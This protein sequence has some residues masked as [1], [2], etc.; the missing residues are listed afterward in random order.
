MGTSSSASSSARRFSAVR[1]LGLTAALA[2]VGL[3][4]PAGPFGTGVT[5]AHAHDVLVGSDP[6]EGA[7]VDVPPEQVVLT[8]SADQMDVGA[9]VQVT[10]PTGEDHVVEGPVTEGREVRTELDGAGDAGEWTVTWRSVSSDGHPISGAFTFTVEAGAVAE[11]EPEPTDETAAEPTEGT[12][13]AAEPTPEVTTEAE[14]AEP[15]AEPTTEDTAD[16]V[17][18]TDDSG[19]SGTSSGISPLLVIGLALAAVAVGVTVWILV[20]RAGPREDD[21]QGTGEQE[22]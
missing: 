4:G 8:F 11:P 13:A 15:T 6:A 3:A 21:P 16:A 5:A 1:L 10:D 2:V 20:R 14:A 9:A 17:T 12:D 22:R 19:T 7:A 18:E